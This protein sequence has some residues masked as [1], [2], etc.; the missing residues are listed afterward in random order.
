MFDHIG[1]H[2]KNLDAS[3]RFYEAALAPLGFVLGSRDATSAGF[4][5]PDAPALWLY[6]DKASTAAHLAFRATTRAAVDK[7]H[8][9]GAAAAGVDHGK[10]GVRADYAP[11]YYAAFLQDPDG[12]NVEAVCLAAP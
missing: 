10:P 5:P 8:Q 1:L 12:N 7:F 2:V 3:V 6:A 4:G 11:T 9:A